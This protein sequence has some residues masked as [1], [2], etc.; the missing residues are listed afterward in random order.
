MP[1]LLDTC[2]NSLDSGQCSNI[3]SVTKK[4]GCFEYQVVAEGVIHG[5]T[6]E[7]DPNT[8]GKN[9]FCDQ[10]NAFSLSRNI[11]LVGF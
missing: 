9:R 6:Y 3:K 1:F 10:N 11:F 4:Y 5:K 2:L 7:G 8:F